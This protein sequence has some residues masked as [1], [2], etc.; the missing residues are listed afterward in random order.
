MSAEIIPLRREAPTVEAAYE[1]FAAA[2]RIAQAKPNIPNM[3]AA[4]DAYRRWL[5]LFV[6]EEGDR[7]S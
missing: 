7:A 2:F 5:P 3:E 1:A 6:A 4:V